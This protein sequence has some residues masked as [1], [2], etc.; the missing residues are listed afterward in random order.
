MVVIVC[1]LCVS[2][3]GCVFR[4]FVHQRFSFPG[5][6]GVRFLCVVC[7]RHKPD[8]AGT[9]SEGLAVDMPAEGGLAPGFLVLKPSSFSSSFSGVST[10]GVQEAADP[11]SVTVSPASSVHSFSLSAQRG[12]GRLHML[13]H[14]STSASASIHS[15]TAQSMA[16]WGA[17]GVSLSLSLCASLSL[18]LSQ[19]HSCRTLTLPPDGCFLG[20]SPAKL[21]AGFRALH[22][23]Q[24]LPGSHHRYHHRSFRADTQVASVSRQYGAHAHHAVPRQRPYP[25]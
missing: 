7:V 25:A 19:S 5:G 23:W 17:S 22:L 3:G 21:A 6:R 13:V 12:S 9:S 8:D 14:N 2:P 11:R 20:T 4:L 16:S 1:S 18:I 24:Q 10:R 15:T